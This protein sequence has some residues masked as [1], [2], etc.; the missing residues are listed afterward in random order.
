M[1]AKK[2]IIRITIILI[3]VN[4][5]VLFR[6]FALSSLVNPTKTGTVPK[7]LM[8][9]NKEANANKNSSIV[10]SANKEWRGDL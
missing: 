4:K 10:F 1:P 5:A 2:E 3:V 9:E 6:S 7:G 8:I